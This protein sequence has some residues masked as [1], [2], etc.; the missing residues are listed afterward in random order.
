MGVAPA[1]AARVQQIK[2]PVYEIPTPLLYIIFHNTTK[3]T[4]GVG[5]KVLSRILGYKERRRL[6]RITE[7]ETA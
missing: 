3:F 4:C 7:R 5:H 2:S 6:E 1:W